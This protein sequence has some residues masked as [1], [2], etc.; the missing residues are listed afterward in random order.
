MA[1]QWVPHL[2]CFRPAGENQG[3]SGSGSGFDLISDDIL[4]DILRRLPADAILQ[5]R[6]VCRHWRTL[7]S[8]THFI[9]LQHQTA[10]SLLLVQCQP[11]LGFLATRRDYFVYDAPAKKLVKIP[12]RSKFGFKG[13]DPGIRTE[14]LSLHDASGP[15][16]HIRASGHLFVWESSF[17]FNLI[18][19]QVQAIQDR[20]MCDRV[21]GIFFNEARNEYNHLSLCCPSH[22]LPTD[23]IMPR[24]FYSRHAPLRAQ[25]SRTGPCS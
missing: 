17:A 8:S 1:I 7:T 21:Y 23:A 12:F 3:G 2:L 19:R 9:N 15:L 14:F 25:S 4:I 18:T 6:K 13:P 16:L 20:T 10:P 5:C 22:P 24:R 11:R